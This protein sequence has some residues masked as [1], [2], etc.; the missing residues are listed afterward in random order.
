MGGAGRAEKFAVRVAGTGEQFA[1]GEDEFVLDAMMR[2]RSGPV[3]HGCC[4]G[5]CG[6]CKMKVERGS[7]FAAKRMSRAHVSEEEQREGIVLL[8]CVQPR[9]D[10]LLSPARHRTRENA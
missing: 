10:L 3:R 1:C 7:V 8:C 6:V 5:G 9:G 2:A 4:G